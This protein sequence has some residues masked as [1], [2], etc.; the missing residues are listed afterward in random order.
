MSSPYQPDEPE[1]TVRTPQMLVLLHSSVVFIRFI[2]LFIYFYLYSWMTID[3][4]IKFVK[5]IMQANQDAYNGDESRRD[6]D[7]KEKKKKK[8][9]SR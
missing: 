6:R 2:Y 5:T 9:R 3:S 4:A 7:R 8:H 1:A